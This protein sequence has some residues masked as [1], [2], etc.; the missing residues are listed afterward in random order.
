MKSV[1]GIKCFVL[2]MD[3]TIYL[4]NRLF[5]YTRD[6]LEKVVRTGRDYVFFT[7]NSSKNA[8]AYIEKL[9]RMGIEIGKEKMLISNEVITDYIRKTYPGKSA[10]VIGTGLLAGDF[11]KAGIKVCEDADLVVLG[12]DTELVY[13]KLVIGCDLIRAGRPFLAVNPDFNCP[14]ENGFIPDCGSIARLITASTGVTPEFFGKPARRA[15]DYMLAKTGCAPGELAVVGDRL[16][17][18]IAIAEGT[19]VTSILVLSGE[20]RREDLEGGGYAPDIV[21]KDLAE[22]A[23]MLGPLT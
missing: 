17:T 22:L 4:G 18:D 21:V 10:Y 1:S 19:D 15:L 8:D 11:E 13:R 9:A 6:F 3:G 14:V 23:E 5:P 12:F 7:N 20:T 16:Y 2:D